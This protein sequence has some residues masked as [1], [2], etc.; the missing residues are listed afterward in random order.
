MRVTDELDAVLDAVS[1]GS[2]V[3]VAIAARS[4]EQAGTDVTLSQCRTLVTLAQRGPMNLVTLAQA[5]GVN[6]STAT[7]M[8]DRLVDKGLVQRE[9]LDGGVSLRPS[10]A[11]LLVIRSVTE[12]RR[13]ELHRIVSKLSD[14]EREAL[15]RCMEAFRVAAGEKADNEWAFGWWD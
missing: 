8:C 11:G 7:R 10:R 9:R 14:G 15:V 5:L 2:R 12:A 1:A 13:A 3:L 4:L 6:P